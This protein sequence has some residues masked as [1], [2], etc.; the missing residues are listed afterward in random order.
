MHERV[1]PDPFKQK[2][3]IHLT[4]SPQCVIYTLDI[5]MLCYGRR[6]ISWMSLDAV[7]GQEA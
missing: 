6:Q 2:K 5:V 3:K 1:C 4:S 7:I